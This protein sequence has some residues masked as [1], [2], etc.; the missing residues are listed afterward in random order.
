MRLYSYDDYQV[1]VG[2]PDGGIVRATQF[3]P[4]VPPRDRMTALI[5]RWERLREP[6]A[7][8]V[9][10]ATPIDLASVRLLPP[11]PHPGLLIAAPVNYRRHQQEMGGE[12]GVYPGMVVH[13]IETY[14][15]FV[16]ASSS[17]VG[18]DDAIELPFEDRRVDH[19]AELGVVIGATASR[20]HRDRAMDYVFGYVPLLD[21]TLR[22]DEDRSYRKSFDTFT[23]IGPAI[24]TRDAV[25]G[26]DALDFRLT[27]NG[28]IRQR[29]N[30]RDLIYGISR[31]VELYSAAMTLHAGDIIA[32]GTPEGV[33]PI[34]PGD[35]V[36]LRIDEVGELRMPVTLRKA[37][38]V[39]RQDQPA[40][41]G[42]S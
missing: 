27:V 20:V 12:S 29:A 22:G 13:T 36:V 8:L 5:E 38:T 9:T 18:P 39:N 2:V 14:A 16:K 42:L 32:T 23:P 11:Q 41:R 33:G 21:I 3:L 34:S 19:E 6:I 7:D 37:L 10:G 15:G 24:V 17:I 28:D 26:A 31:L 25:P 35:E 4:D 30:T 1:G 40:I